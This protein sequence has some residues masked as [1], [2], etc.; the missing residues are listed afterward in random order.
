MKDRLLKFM[1][2]ENISAGKLAEIIGVQPSAISHITSGRNKPGFDFLA[3]LFTK[4]P[5]LNPKWIIVGEGSMTISPETLSMKPLKKESESP[6]R[7]SAPSDEL[8]GVPPPTATTIESTFLSH[9]N[10]N[11]PKS[12]DQPKS[13]ER[14]V[15]FYSDGTFSSYMNNNDVS[16][17]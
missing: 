13:I 8:L 15:L 2:S 16:A 4:F 14:I 6:S 1:Q 7:V 10:N 12:V 9:S 5:N 11:R 3:G 17:R